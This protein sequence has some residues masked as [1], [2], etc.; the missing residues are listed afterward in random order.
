MQKQFSLISLNFSPIH[1]TSAEGTLNGYVFGRFQR[2]QLYYGES[3]RSSCSYYRATP[4]NAYL[5]GKS[6][7]YNDCYHFK[8]HTRD[9]C[10][11]LQCYPKRKEGGSSS[12]ANSVA[13]GGNHLNDGGS[14]DP[15]I[16]RNTRFYVS[17]SSIPTIG[18]Q[19]PG[20]LKW[21]GRGDDKDNQARS[22]S[23]CLCALGCEL[24][25]IL[26]ESGSWVV[27]E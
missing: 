5:N 6:H 15:L 25:M 12:H 20:S 26:G 23:P 7:L 11:K 18:T 17:S 2:I 9:H 8:G 3:C 21:Q 27:S 14:Y 4:R 1:F 16:S 13:T 24:H 10:Y 22:D 19:A